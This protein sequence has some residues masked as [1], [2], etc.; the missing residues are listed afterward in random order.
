MTPTIKHTGDLINTCRVS[1]TL[2]QSQKL[3][4]EP[5]WEFTFKGTPLQAPNRYVTWYTQSYEDALN[6]I[7][8]EEIDEYTISI[9]T[10]YSPS[11]I[12]VFSENPVKS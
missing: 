9:R 2:K 5:R 7:N 10:E 12:Q 3:K 11:G 1:V 4:E 6:S 8:I